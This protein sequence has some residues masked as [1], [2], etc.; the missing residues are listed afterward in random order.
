MT[1]NEIKTQINDFRIF[2]QKGN[3]KIKDKIGNI[4]PLVLN[5]AQE[6][7]LRIIEG[8]ITEGVPIRIIILKAR[9]KG[10]STLIEAYIFWRTTYSPNRKSAVIG[11]VRDATDNLW[12]MTNRYYDNLPEY[13]QPEKKY[14]NS[15]ELTYAKT[16]SEMI[17]WTAETGDVGS[18]HTIQDLHITEL[19]KWRDP[20]TTLTSLLQT[21]PDEPNTMVIM[22]STANGFGGEFYNRCQSSILG[23]SKYKFIFLS[24]LIDDEYT[25]PFSNDV[26]RNDFI[27]SMDQEEKILLTKGATYEHLKWRR[28]IGLPDKCG[29]DPDKFK[30]EY[31]ADAIEAFITSGRPV[32][33]AEKC[34]GNF[35]KA[36]K[37]PY[38][39]G[40]FEFV[41]DPVLT[42]KPI[43]VKFIHDSNGYVKIYKEIEIEKTEH[44][45]FAA[46]CDV[47]EGLEQG[48]YSVVKV[49][50]R[51]T[52]EVALTWHGHIDADLLAEEQLKIQL[53]LKGNV[54]FGT[55]F[56]NHGQTTV[57]EAFK[58]G[59]NQYYR[60]D[61][62]TGREIHKDILGFK[63]T[64]QTKPFIINDLNESIRENLI[65]DDEP[66][67]WSECL[68]FVRNAK[69]GVGAQDKDKDP[70]VKCF[71][72]RV[73]ASAIMIKVHKWLPNYYKEKSDVRKAWQIRLAEKKKQKMDSGKNKF[74][75][76]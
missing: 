6:T 62:K 30:Q 66:E 51:R 12:D 10:I 27:N 59:V 15:K 18:S 32:F 33:N 38:K 73:M 39:Q 67:F 72:D 55:E 48:D 9:Q 16:K 21:V 36:Q 63:T 2:L 7:V 71:D 64:A 47:A 8:M 76:A 1:L 69:G 28:E 13:F 5:K 52:N 20:K 75:R 29:N 34:Q 54:Y 25:L 45:V 19:S 26:E 4:V 14:H 24:W 53:Y 61:F 41:Y 37:K 43:D 23:E 57:Y 74:M 44:Y 68:T 46:G 65:K 11:H 3:L 56:N 17:F 70:G 50:D 42:D 49:L 58:L 40:Y 31:P 60:E 22:E 35:V